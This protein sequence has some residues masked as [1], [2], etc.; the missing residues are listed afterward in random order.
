MLRRNAIAA[1]VILGASVLCAGPLEADEP[2]Q[3]TAPTAQTVEPAPVKTGKER[4]SGKASD[5]QRVDNCKVSPELRGSRPRSDSCENK[6]HRS[7]PT[8]LPHCT[9]HAR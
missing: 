3:T 8:E 9:L 4:L 5:E 7:P 1:T 2:V 6:T